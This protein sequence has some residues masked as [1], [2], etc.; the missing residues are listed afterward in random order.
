VLVV[1]EHLVVAD[2]GALLADALDPRDLRFTGR[3]L[4]VSRTARPA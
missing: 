4:I 2:H 3:D 1:V